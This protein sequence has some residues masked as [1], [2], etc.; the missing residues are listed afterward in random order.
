MT[1]IRTHSPRISLALLLPLMHLV[2][3]AA[4]LSLPACGRVYYDAINEATLP[5]D[6]L[7]DRRITEADRAIGEARTALLHLDDALRDF[8]L[9]PSGPSDASERAQT[10]L[11]R[12]ATRAEAAAADASRRIASVFDVAPDHL[13][14]LDEDDPALD[15]FDALASAL[16]AADDA[17]A[18]T[19]ADLSTQ[20]PALGAAPAP[21]RADALRAT[22][23]ATIRDLDAAHAEAVAFTAGSAAAD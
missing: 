4:V 14:T 5:T 21:S 18:R 17:L 8:A 12:L 9:T 2:P 11:E 7:L 6:Q 13:A 15:R 10:D 23:D 1:R 3:A 22:I 19:L 16:T 20:I